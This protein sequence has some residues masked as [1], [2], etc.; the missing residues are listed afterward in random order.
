LVEPFRKKAGGVGEWIR[1]GTE[2]KKKG[3]KK[4]GPTYYPRK[5]KSQKK[6]VRD[7]GKTE[8]QDLDISEIKKIT[9]KGHF[10]RNPSIMP[11][12]T[13]EGCNQKL[14]LSQ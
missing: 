8:A 4:R 2:G 3:N 11:N 14:W 7:W 9:H 6:R 1:G 5:K 13:G 10:T 12:E